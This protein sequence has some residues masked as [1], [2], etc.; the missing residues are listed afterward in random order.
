MFLSPVY[1]LTIENKQQHTERTGAQSETER[2]S[3]RPRSIGE[4]DRSGFFRALFCEQIGI[5]LYNFLKEPIRED[6]SMGP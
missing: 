4:D 5:L 6:R 1:H 3:L 2:N